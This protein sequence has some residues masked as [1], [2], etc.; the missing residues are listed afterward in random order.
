MGKFLRKLTYGAIGV[1]LVSSLGLA[2]Y[3]VNYLHENTDAS[4]L[5][6]QASAIKDE[7][8]MNRSID[9]LVENISALSNPVV[10]LIAFTQYDERINSY[11]DRL[12]DE[13]RKNAKETLSLAVFIDDETSGNS[14]AAEYDSETA[15]RTVE[16]A[17]TYLADQR[18][19]IKLEEVVNVRIPQIYFDNPAEQNNFL[20]TIKNT[21]QSEFDIGI[22]VSSEYGILSS[23]VDYLDNIVLGYGTSPRRLGELLATGL[24]EKKLAKNPSQNS[25]DEK[26]NPNQSSPNARTLKA[27]VYLCNVNQ[28]YVESLIGSVSKE[29]E[30]NFGIK[31]QSVGYKRVYDYE[32]ENDYEPAKKQLRDMAG[33]PSDVYILFTTWIPE[34]TVGGIAGVKEGTVMLDSSGNPKEDRQKLRHEIGHLFG[35]E[36]S[37]NKGDIMYIGIV[38]NHQ[39]WGMRDVYVIKENRFRMWEFSNTQEAK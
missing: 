19:F 16:W 12:Q 29:F 26:V 6:Q 2:R 32:F 24:K 8:R 37:Y 23:R 7:G 18:T 34:A 9:S 31:V 36:H 4:H 10:R 35:A 14:R 5:L 20:E 30:E 39:T 17:N 3:N 22:V 21:A 13:L 28:G 15:R 1:A 38:D 11:R 33:E 25:D 27:T